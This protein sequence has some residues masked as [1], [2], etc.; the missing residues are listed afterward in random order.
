MSD[1][2]DEVLE[3]WNQLGIEV[4]DIRAN[5]VAVNSR[6]IYINSMTKFIEV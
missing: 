1:D 2:G 5:T 6:A 3:R 4:A